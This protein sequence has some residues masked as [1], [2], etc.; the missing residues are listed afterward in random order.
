MPSALQAQPAPSSNIATAARAF[1]DAYPPVRRQWRLRGVGALLVATTAL[2]LPWM[3]GSLNRHAL[4]LAVPFAAANVFS[5]VY[6]LLS[7]VNTW[8]RR[9]PEPRSLPAGDEPD[10]AVL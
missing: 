8:S 2:Y 10:V 1:G 5:M 4:W 9:V 3:L 6:A 7:V